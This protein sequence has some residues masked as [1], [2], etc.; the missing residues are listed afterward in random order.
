MRLGSTDMQIYHVPGAVLLLTFYFQSV[1]SAL[2]SVKVEFNGTAVLPCSE[3]CS[4]VVRWSI[5]SRWSQ[6]PSDILAECDQTSC[7]SLKEGYQMIHDQYLQGNLSLIISEADF[8]KRSWYT[9]NCDVEKICYV[10]LRLE[11]PELSLQIKAGESLTLDFPVS[12]PVQVMFNRTGDAN[13]VPV[14]VFEGSKIQCDP[15]YEK[16]AVLGPQLKELKISDSGVYTLVDTKNE[17][18]VSIFRI[19]VIEEKRS[20]VWRFWEKDECFIVFFVGVGLGV[21]VGIFVPPQIMR[22]SRWLWRKVR[23]LRGDDNSDKSSAAA[24]AG[25]S[26]QSPGPEGVPLKEPISD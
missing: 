11:P 26:D 4:G 13:A 3:R 16:R 25:G 23:R 8:S 5:L 17:E 21:L 10:S 7:R 12:E 6:N 2:P 18:V 20:W 24:A 19:T 22:F 15:V 14:K 1:E 9:C